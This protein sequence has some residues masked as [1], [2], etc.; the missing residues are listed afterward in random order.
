MI[1]IITTTTTTIIIIII[2]IFII[3]SMVMI[4]VDIIMLICLPAS[5]AAEAVRKACLRAPSAH[6]AMIDSIDMLFNLI[7]LHLEDT[8]RAAFVHSLAHQASQTL[9]P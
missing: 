3:S 4:I 9:R 2:I 6:S 5:E 7:S 8:S 1:I